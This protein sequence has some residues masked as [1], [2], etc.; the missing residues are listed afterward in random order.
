MT[1]I[2]GKLKVKQDG[3]W[4]TYGSIPT[5]GSNGNVLRKQS[6]LD[7]DYAWE[8]ISGLPSDVTASYAELN[9]LD[10][11]TASTSD[12]NKLSGLTTNSSKL[13]YCSGLNTDLKNMMTDNLPWTGTT[14]TDLLSITN[15]TITHETEYEVNLSNYLPNDTKKY[16]IWIQANCTAQSSGQAFAVA[17]VS[18]VIDGYVYVCGSGGTT[19]YGVVIALVGSNHK[20][21]VKGI[22]RTGDTRGKGIYIGA[23]GYREMA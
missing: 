16:E 10:G 18:S 19:G 12:L 2:N 8:T 22:C 11:C 20:F 13:N 1:S 21:T 14:N 15:A 3:E 17:I 6:D 9:I 5:S 4:V 23:R 7:Y